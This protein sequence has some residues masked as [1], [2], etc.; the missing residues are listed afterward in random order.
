M[1]NKLHPM[2]NNNFSVDC[3]YNEGPPKVGWLFNILPVTLPDFGGSECSAIDLYFL[4][5]DGGTFKAALFYQPYIYVG[6][7]D[8]QQVGCCFQFCSDELSSGTTSTSLCSDD[9]KRNCHC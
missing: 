8:D 1:N 5:E 3:R 9:V 6:V 7:S 2:V 4:E